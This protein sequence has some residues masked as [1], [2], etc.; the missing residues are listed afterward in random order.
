MN[1]KVHN[2]IAG[3]IQV[4]CIKASM[5]RGGLSDLLRNNF[6]SV[7]PVPRLFIKFEGIKDPNWLAGFVDGEGFF[8]VGVSKSKNVISGFSV[9]V[10]FAVS[11]HI[12][13]EVLLTKFIDYL[14]CGRISKANSRPDSLTF[15]VRKLSDIK[16]KIIPF[17][18]KYPLQGEK[19]RDFLDFCKVVKIMEDKSHLT[20]L[21]IKRIKSI[22]SGMNKGRI[23]EDL[24]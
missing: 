24:S 13:D 6:P 20:E 11:Q 4:L 9:S 21:G 17:F 16:D 23:S 15:T 19:S 2:E 5:N 10:E 7:L 3:I 22:K 18:Q 12:R 1:L 14:L 8:Y